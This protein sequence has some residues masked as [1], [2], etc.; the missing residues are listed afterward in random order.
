VETI[1]ATI[2]STWS[3]A[4]LFS[5]FYTFVAGL[6]GLLVLWATFGRVGPRPTDVLA[7]GF[8]GLALPVPTQLE[9]ISAWIGSHGQPLIDL[10]I[11]GAA[12]GLVLSYILLATYIAGPASVRGP[13]TFWVA[14]AVYMEV[15]GRPGFLQIALALAAVCLLFLLPSAISRI[16]DSLPDLRE[17]RDHLGELVFGA[18]FVLLVPLWVV[19][20]GLGGKI[21]GPSTGKPTA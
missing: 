5:R 17:Y 18:V 11:N 19:W 2:M 9:S 6:L 13:A 14:A 21:K 15:R 3:A 12:L 16:S 20:S 1:A 8:E 4:N 7:A 10:S